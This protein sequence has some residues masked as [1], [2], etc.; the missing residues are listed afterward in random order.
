MLGPCS[1]QL[2]CEWRWPWG[3]PRQPRRQTSSQRG[4]PAQTRSNAAR[5]RRLGSARDH[6]QEGRCRTAA[7]AL[8]FVAAH[9]RLE[10]SAAG[11]A[12]CETEKALETR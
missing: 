5:C 8:R 6:T 10:A 4:L 2:R 3:R 1:I 9:P 12:D 7:A 11:D